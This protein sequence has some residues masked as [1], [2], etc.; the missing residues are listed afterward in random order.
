MTIKFCQHWFFTLD[1]LGQFWKA[2]AKK[3]MY[4]FTLFNIALKK[5]RSFKDI[6]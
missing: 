4:F 6:F 3:A 2:T 1:F 5:S